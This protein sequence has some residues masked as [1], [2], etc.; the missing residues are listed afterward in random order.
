MSAPGIERYDAGRIAAMADPYPAYAAL[1]ASGRLLPAGPGA[2][3]VPRYE[4]VA[5]LLRDPRLG[6]EFPDVMYRLSGEPDVLTEFFRAT[7]LNRDAPS[8]PVLRRAMAALLA[9]RA[10]ARLRPR[11][12]EL[13]A[14]LLGDL[15][16]AGTGDLVEG[17]AYPLPVIVSSELLGIPAADRDRLRP[18]AVAL[19]R[20]FGAGIQPAGDRDA[21]IAAVH[22]LRGYVRGLLERAGDG[23]LSGVL[24]AGRDAGLAAAEVVDNVIFLF[25]AGF[26]T[27]TNLIANGCAALLES[28]A[29]LETLRGDPALAESAVEE[30]LRFEAPIQ[31]TARVVREPVEIGGRVLRARRLVLLLLASA[32]RDERRFAAPDRIDLARSPNPHLSFSS[33]VHHCLGATLARIEGAAVFAQ[34]AARRGRFVPAGP[35][36]RRDHPSFRGFARLP[37]RFG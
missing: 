4:D 9:P 27:T 33:G 5:A 13:V 1:R 3:A 16:G 7:V 22:W 31:A 17:L 20:A 14:R 18:H 29:L 19:G 25:F 12:D 11:I 37:V 28:P 35:P 32:N 24:A 2:W 26:D 21:A 23:P 15:A 36:R 8:H 34:L 6:H 30:F 10:V